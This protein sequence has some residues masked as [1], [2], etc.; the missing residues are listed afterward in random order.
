MSLEAMTWVF[1]HSDTTLSHRLVLLVLAD[2]ANDDT[3]EA[4]PSVGTIASKAR[5]SERQARYALRALEAGGHIVAVGKSQLQT[6]IYRVVKDPS[7]TAESAGG[8]DSQGG[9]LKQEGGHPI[10]P[11]PS[12]NHQASTSVTDDSVHPKTTVVARESAGSVDALFSDPAAPS[13]VVELLEP[14]RVAKGCGR[15]TTEAL[16]K[17]TAA[18]PQVDHAAVA[19]ELAFWALHG[20]GKQRKVKSLAGTFRTFVRIASERGGGSSAVHTTSSAVSSSDKSWDDHV[21]Y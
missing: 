3:W 11:K 8:Q 20:N 6:T 12:E 9:N 5:I 2:N 14:V 15:I 4:Y 16:D 17:I 13:R 19:E 1:R 10:A 21:S 7:P 18:Y